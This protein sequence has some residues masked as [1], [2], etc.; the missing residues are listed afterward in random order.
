M[1]DRAIDAPANPGRNPRDEVVTIDE[2]VDILPL[3]RSK[4]YQL[5]TSGA[6]PSYSVGRRRYIR[7]DEAIT[8]WDAQRYDPA[9]EL[10]D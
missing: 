10:D 1:V 4:I 3:G 6:I 9:Q 2:L 5:V 7:R 8:W